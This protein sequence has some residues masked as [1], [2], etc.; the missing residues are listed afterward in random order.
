VARIRLSPIGFWSYSRRDDILAKGKLGDLRDLIVEEIE[1]QL[2]EQALVFKDTLSI[3]HGTRWEPM[4]KRA[5]SNA[6]FFI[7]IL[8]PNFLKSEWC[9]R[10]VRLFLD[11]EEQI[12]ALHPELA[13]RSRIFPIHYIDTTDADT[14][15]EDVVETLME[16]QNLDFLEMRHRGCDEAPV[17]SKVAAFVSSIRD[18]MRIRVDDDPAAAEPPKRQRTGGGTP[19][20][21]ATPPPSP[22]AWDTSPPPPSPPPTPSPSPPPPTPSP[23]PPPP[24][25]SPS[26]PPPKPAPPPPAG[27]GVEE[28]AGTRGADVASIRAVAIGI[29]ALI[30]VV[31]LIALV[32]RPSPAPANYTV[33]AGTAYNDVS[34]E[35]T[36]VADAT[37]DAVANAVGDNAAA[38]VSTGPRIIAMS[39]CDTD[40]NF[41]VNWSNGTGRRI[42]GPW[43]IA[44]NGQMPLEA[45]SGEQVYPTDGGIYFYGVSP[46]GTR[47]VQ[48]SYTKDF[49]GL[50]NR[51][52][53]Y[54]S[55]PVS[56]S[57]DYSIRFYCQ[58]PAST[59]SFG[60]SSDNT[61]NSH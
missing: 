34:N 26:P 7:P 6:T 4:T 10:E 11:R 38:F 40:I 45:E 3:P 21:V 18:L 20:P 43:L 19:A 42:G 16:L 30:G 35:A 14:R 5:L 28:P 50:G 23:S 60:N 37:T 32:S 1:A 22:P 54:A 25:P 8:T 41:Y 57:G 53:V 58:A 47:V 49:L 48:G 36:N 17:R 52:G 55:V 27:P 39:S 29:G 2:G 9:C 24:T 46:G 59:N 31:I 13:G 33:D 56:S 51:P 12:G 15:D 44:A 61:S